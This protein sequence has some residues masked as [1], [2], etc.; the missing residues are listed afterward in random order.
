MTGS[1]RR[2]RLA[3]GTQRAREGRGAG[4]VPELLALPFLQSGAR[5]DEW[6]IRARSFG[7]VARN[8]LT[9]GGAS[10]PLR[11]LDLGAGNGWLCYRSA[12]EGHHSVAL[13]IRT[14]AV[15]GLGAAA[16]YAA[17]LS[18][19]FPRIAATFEALPLSSAAFDLVVFNASIH[20]A[21]DL[22]ATL[23]EACRVTQPGGTLLIVDSPFY[24]KEVWGV[25]MVAEKRKAAPGMFGPLVEELMAFPFVEFLTPGRLVK[26]S[27]ALGLQWRR[28][29]VRYPWRY[30]LRP[31]LARLRGK[32]PPSRFDVW[33]TSVPGP[34]A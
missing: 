24:A 25:A 8:W 4:G 31:L 1:L 12:L 16:H 10:H 23:R 14:D 7:Y 9:R 22:E 13:D 26:S 17:H 5:A 32:R 34:R 29:R 28:H 30:E 18:A 20:Y 21:V 3:Y 6:R 33:S 11:I 15:D 19:M 2:F 27:K